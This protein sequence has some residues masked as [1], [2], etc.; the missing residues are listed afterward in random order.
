MISQEEIINRLKKVCGIVYP[1]SFMNNLCFLC[2]SIEV[3]IIDTRALKELLKEIEVMC[4][5]SFIRQELLGK[6]KPLTVLSLLGTQL[7]EGEPKTKRRKQK[8]E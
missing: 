7:S 5:A 2:D 1:L 4:L 8:N 6:D 3:A